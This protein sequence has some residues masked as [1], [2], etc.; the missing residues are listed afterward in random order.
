MVLLCIPCW[1]DCLDHTAGGRANRST[2][3]VMV[4][5]HDQAIVIL[6]N[7]HKPSALIAVSGINIKPD[8]SLVFRFNKIT[9]LELL[10]SLKDVSLS[11]SRSYTQ[12]LARRAN[13][14]LP[15]DIVRTTRPRHL[16]ESCQLV[17]WV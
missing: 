4:R 5:H 9:S 7:L 2:F 17:L 3:R 10:D 1:L 14:P 13:R 12:E 11:V 8:P 15:M 6:S 16:L